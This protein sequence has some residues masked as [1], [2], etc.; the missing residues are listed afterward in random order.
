M[1]QKA[2]VSRDVL[3]N[4]DIRL[5][6][7][8]HIALGH[9]RTSV[10]TEE[11]FASLALERLREVASD[12][13]GQN[14]FY[15]VNVPQKSHW[16]IASPERFELTHGRERNNHYEELGG[17]EVC[18]WS[19]LAKGCLVMGQEHFEMALSTRSLP[20]LHSQDM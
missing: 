4:G 5:S 17:V 11:K 15:R 1:Q 9:D 19:S 14:G 10:I 6:L 16:G 7:S 12:V 13:T 3:P 20:E 2:T 8:P 18:V